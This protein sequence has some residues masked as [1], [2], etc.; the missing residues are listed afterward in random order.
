M[1]ED[2]NKNNIEVK[3]GLELLNDKENQMVEN[4][5]RTIPVPINSED[6]LDAEKEYAI[7]QIKQEK[8]LNYVKQKIL[9]KD[10]Y[11][12]I[13]DKKFI[14][15]SGVRRLMSAFNISI[16]SVKILSIIER[17]WETAPPDYIKQ[18]GNKKEI[19]V[20]AQATAQK[21]VT[22]SKN[23]QTF[24]IVRQEMV[25]TAG[26]SSREAYEKHQPYKFHNIIATAETRAK[27]RSALDMLSGD[28][29]FEEITFDEDIKPTVIK[30][31]AEHNYQEG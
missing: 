14:K 13:R 29:S 7:M 20:V 16:S 30:N 22:V 11:Q 10:D 9:T 31:N 3:N 1:I 25:A 27:S 8:L 21:K 24:S 26:Y 17:D 18:I 23:G 28:V 19:I 6:V 15:K 2:E 5:I 4:Y 12:E